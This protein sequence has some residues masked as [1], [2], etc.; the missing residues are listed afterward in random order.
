MEP[1]V[2][3]APPDFLTSCLSHGEDKAATDGHQLGFKLEMQAKAVGT[4]TL[5]QRTVVPA[6]R[7][8]L[9]PNE[10][11]KRTQAAGR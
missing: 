10:P 9:L 11:Q 7:W 1:G 3:A 2:A 6:A 5:P 4:E 8:P